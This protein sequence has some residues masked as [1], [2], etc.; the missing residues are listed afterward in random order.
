MKKIIL[1]FAF[2]SVLLGC[3]PTSKAITTPT[4]NGIQV[5]I[6][7][8]KIKDDKVMVT[9]AAPT[10]STNEITY[11][12]PKMVPGTYS[13]DNYGKYIEGLKAYNKKGKLDIKGA[14]FFLAQIVLA[15]GYL[16]YKKSFIGI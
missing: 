7:L 4:K 3:K 10:I 12:I 2:A 11:H 5:D 6:N 8:D 9:I 14:I 1:A 13:E 15:I 16:H